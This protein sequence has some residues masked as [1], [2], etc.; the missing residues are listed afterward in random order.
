M[1]TTGL[2][3]AICQDDASSPII[4]QCNHAYCGTCFEEWDMTCEENDR[5]TPCPQCNQVVVGV[6]ELIVIDDSSENAGDFHGGGC[7]HTHVVLITIDD[8][9]TEEDDS[10]F[11]VESQRVI[12]IDSDDDETTHN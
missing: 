10:D 9:D 2:I 7:L 5:V 3:C 1:A 4:L 12:V 11:V 6:H 8:S